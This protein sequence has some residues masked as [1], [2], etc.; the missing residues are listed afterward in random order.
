MADVMNAAIGANQ[1]WQIIACL[2]IENRKNSEQLDLVAVM[3]ERL[4]AR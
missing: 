2:V 3:P 1:G 4:M